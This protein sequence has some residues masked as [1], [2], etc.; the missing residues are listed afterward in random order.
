MCLMGKG[1]CADRDL[2]NYNSQSHQE[3]E[4]RDTHA[5]ERAQTGALDAYGESEV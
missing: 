4:G 1:H 5:S 3:R 2:T